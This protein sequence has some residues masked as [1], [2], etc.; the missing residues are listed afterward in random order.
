MD[1]Q[2]K[3]EKVLNS[4]LRGI[5][6]GSSETIYLNHRLLYDVGEVAIPEIEKQLMSYNWTKA[7]TGIELKI[8]TGLL[9]LIHDIDEKR[10]NRVAENIRDKGC[11][12]IVESR[13]GSILK[14]TLNE[15]D[16]YQIRNVDI[17]QSKELTYTRRIERKMKKWLS[18][19]PEKDLEDIER[20]YLIPEQN[21]DYR[22]TYMPIL[23]NIMVEW[24]LKTS[25]FN[26]LSYFM[27]LQIEKTLY[28]EIGHHVH[29]HRLSQSG[30]P[31][32]EKEANRYA[33]KLIEKN[34]PV[35]KWLVKSVK[36]LF[37][38]KKKSDSE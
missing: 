30:D 20:L 9:G 16:S 32:L 7:K 4:F 19:V 21:T 23:C 27:L 34:H 35:L 6:I 10:A 17:Y 26:P 2:Q 28:H 14:F 29:R 31:E 33:Y 3:I 36:F 11:S 25:W 22:G 38:R 15:F 8:L 5:T 1:K 13:I 37:G 24:D 18:S 12:K